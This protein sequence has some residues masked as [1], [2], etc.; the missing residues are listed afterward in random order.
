MSKLKGSKDPTELTPE[1]RNSVGGHGADVGEKSR[2]SW[3]KK[4]EEFAYI[5]KIFKVK[6][7]S[8]W[9]SDRKSNEKHQETHQSVN[10]ILQ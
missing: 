8:D 4:E 1:S 5:M 9:Q 2:T 10:A 7:I 3:R 6:K